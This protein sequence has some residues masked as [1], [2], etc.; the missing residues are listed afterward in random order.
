MRLGIGLSRGESFLFCDRLRP[1]GRCLKVSDGGEHDGL[2]NFLWCLSSAEEIADWSGWAWSNTVE[3]VGQCQIQKGDVSG[4]ALCS[5]EHCRK[6]VSA[7]ANVLQG[8][9]HLIYW[10]FHLYKIYFH[11]NSA[12]E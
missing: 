3:L 2:L 8:N 11:V 10:R 7:Q 6:P 4:L 1:C 5:K 9:S 12:S